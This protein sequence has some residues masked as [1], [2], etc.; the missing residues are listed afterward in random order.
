MKTLPTF[1]SSA[2]SALRWNYAGSVSRLVLGLC[3]N[4]FL[5]R[6]LGPKPFGQL[7]VALIVNSLAAL[8][9]DVGVSSALIQKPNLDERD[10]RYGFTIQVAMG[11]LITCILFFAAPLWAHFF[12]DPGLSPIL[13]TL[14]MIFFIQGLGL[15]SV[16][17][18]KKSLEFRTLQICFISSYLIAYLGVGIP[19]AIR[20]AGVWSL[21]SAQLS[22]ITIQTIALHIS[23]RHSLRPLWDPKHSALLT[24]GARVLGANLS[25]WGISNLDNTFVGRIDGS[26]ALGLYGRAF[27]LAQLPG[28]AL[29]S[30]MQQVLLPALSRVQSDRQKLARVYQGAVGAVALVL[31]PL[32]S[33]MAVVPY[34]IIVGLYGNKWTGAVAVF[35]PLALS[36]PI[37]AMM[38]L[39]GPALAAMGKTQ[40]EMKVQAFGLIFAI[41]AYWSAVHYSLPLLGWSVFAVYILRFYLMT[42]AI[43]NEL[44]L[45]WN[46]LLKVVSPAFALG[47]ITTLTA[48]LTKIATSG[49][50]PVYQLIC[51]AIADGIVVLITLHLGSKL[52]LRPIFYCIPELHSVVPPSL[53]RFLPVPDALS[54]SVTSCTSS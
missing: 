38:A 32:F 49:L 33:A 9:S 29:I 13:R 44:G 16:A 24:F 31:V 40:V 43:C 2:V 37:H 50:A 45:R 1:A 12:H 10:V 42:T 26:E 4:V 18:L 15:T 5:T 3:V 21:V 48:V 11:L 27:L 23:V 54:L 19:L 6:L 30:T 28:D 34:A 53:E 46:G 36:M 17:L 8:L 51:V 39:T 22:Q 52:F 7:S 14:S 35:S 47:S 41:G 20:G 25:N